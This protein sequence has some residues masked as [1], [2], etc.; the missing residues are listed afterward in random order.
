MQGQHWKFFVHAFILTRS[1]KMLKK[2]IPMTG[3]NKGCDVAAT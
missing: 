1:L 3:E 2:S